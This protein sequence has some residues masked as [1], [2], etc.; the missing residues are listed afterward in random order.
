MTLKPSIEK[1]KPISSQSFFSF[2]QDL[3]KVLPSFR[4]IFMKTSDIISFS[5][6]NFS[7]WR[8]KWNKIMEFLYFSS[9]SK[10]ESIKY[11]KIN[12]PE[13]N[14]NFVN[15][16]SRKNLLNLKPKLQ[17]SE[18]LH[19]YSVWALKIQIF[20]ITM[21]SKLFKKKKLFATPRTDPHFSG[22][23]FPFILKSNIPKNKYYFC[24]L[25]FVLWFWLF[26]KK[27]VPTNSKESLR[28]DTFSL[29]SKISLWHRWNLSRHSSSGFKKNYRIISL[30]HESE[31]STTWVFVNDVHLC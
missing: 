14:V 18:V 4:L 25:W 10:T 26:Y 20:R 2:H 12:A 30:Q 27:K 3:H 13:T 19:C 6:S 15:V 23:F 29:D 11:L 24:E 9:F 1:G 22:D 5:L 31:I 8:F 17:K 7:I 21:S 28:V 16:F